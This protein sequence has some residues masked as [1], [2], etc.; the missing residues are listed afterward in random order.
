[1]NQHE[2]KSYILKQSLNGRK[3]IKTPK[4]SN[5]ILLLLMGT[6]AIPMRRGGHF[7]FA[8]EVS[9]LLQTLEHNQAIVSIASYLSKYLIFLLF[10]RWYFYDYVIFR[11]LIIYF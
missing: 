10:N 8:W 4:V 3:N 11:F 2:P 7:F 1:M 9:G 6:H 5:T